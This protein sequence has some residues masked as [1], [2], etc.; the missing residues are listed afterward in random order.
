[1]TKYMV[2]VATKYENEDGETIEDGTINGM[3]D[4]FHSAE[5]HALFDVMAS[6]LRDEAVI[7]GMR[8]YYEYGNR[9]GDHNIVTGWLGGMR[10]VVDIYMERMNIND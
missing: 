8:F 3:F 2:I 7:D 1:M 4:N 6:Y 5:Q 9:I 10:C